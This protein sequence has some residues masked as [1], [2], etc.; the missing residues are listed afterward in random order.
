MRFRAPD[1][2]APSG[3]SA[4]MHKTLMAVDPIHRGVIVGQSQVLPM[5]LIV[6]QQWVR[7]PQSTWDSS[8]RLIDPQCPGTAGADASLV[9]RAT[10]VLDLR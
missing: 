5:S 1:S 8:T 9:I 6:G 10:P 4:E 7:G 3:R 2:P